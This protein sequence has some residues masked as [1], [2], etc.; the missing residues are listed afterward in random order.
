MSFTA[1]TLKNF[2]KDNLTE[3]SSG[4]ILCEIMLL[5]FC[6]KTGLILNQHD[7]STIWKVTFP[8]YPIKS[9]SGIEK[10]SGIRFL[11]RNNKKK[12]GK[13]MECVLDLNFK[14]KKYHRA[15][16]S[17]V[18]NIST[19]KIRLLERFSLIHWVLFKNGRV[20]Y[21]TTI[22]KTKEFLELYTQSK[23]CKE[24][25]CVISEVT[26]GEIPAKT[27]NCLIFS[28]SKEIDFTT[29]NPDEWFA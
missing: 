4:E 18:L 21:S 11:E 3:Y 9:L 26:G 29:V 14:S 7:F 20:N 5:F 1:D 23:K 24:L 6:E 28:E 22:Q 15:K 25:K 16:L 13:E 2:F 19:E 8:Q 12:M 27:E 10:I 17:K